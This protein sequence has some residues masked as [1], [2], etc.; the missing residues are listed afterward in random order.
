MCIRFIIVLKQ[1][2]VTGATSCQELTSFMGVN[3]T[4]EHKLKNS[5]LF[6]CIVSILWVLII[7]WYGYVKCRIPYQGYN[8]RLVVLA[9]KM[10]LNVGFDTSFYNK[11][12]W[13]E[14]RENAREVSSTK[15]YVTNDETPRSILIGCSTSCIKNNTCQT[16]LCLK[17][18]VLNVTDSFYYWQYQMDVLP[19]KVGLLR[20]SDTAAP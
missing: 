12:D 6:Q 8:L 19:R 13:K 16:W 7:F 14:T 17:S 10:A 11:K 3:Y 2:Q 1:F 18:T 5:I 15:A 9:W 4:V 20:L